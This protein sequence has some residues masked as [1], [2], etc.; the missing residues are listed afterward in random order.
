MQDGYKTKEV[1]GNCDIKG[2]NRKRSMEV[3]LGELRTGQKR[4]TLPSL[5]QKERA[6]QEVEMHP[7]SPLHFQLPISIKEVF[8]RKQG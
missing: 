8:I 7:Q 6:Y 5:S 3:D 1:Q 4:I 2:M